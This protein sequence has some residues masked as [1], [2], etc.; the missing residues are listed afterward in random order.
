MLSR[1]SHNLIQIKKLRTT[2]KK[3]QVLSIN[4]KRKK[5]G[6]ETKYMKYTCCKKLQNTIFICFLTSCICVQIT[7]LYNKIIYL[8]QKCSQYNEKVIEEVV[9]KLP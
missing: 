5:K 8:K 7:K 3:L 2:N 6:F 4:Y 1:K 9:S